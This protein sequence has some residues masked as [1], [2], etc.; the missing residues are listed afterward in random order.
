MIEHFSNLGVELPIV[1]D[2]ILVNFDEQRTRAAIEEL[3][4]QTGDNQ[5]VLF[6]TCHQHLAEMFRQQG[7]STVMLPERRA[8]NDELK[9][10]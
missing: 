8:I 6:F 2:D 10:G 7:V 4:R 9:A 1:L 5:Q 3:T